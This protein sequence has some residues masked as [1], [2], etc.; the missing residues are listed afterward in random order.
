MGGPAGQAGLADLLSQLLQTVPQPVKNVVGAPFSE[1][2]G[3]V[4]GPGPERERALG[5]AQTVGGVVGGL[6]A[7][8][9]TKAQFLKIFKAPD[10]SVRNVAKAVKAKSGKVFTDPHEHGTA[11]EK[12]FSSGEEP[13]EFGLHLKGKGFI[14]ERLEPFVAEVADPK[15]DIF[16]ILFRMAKMQGLF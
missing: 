8:V 13:V 12:A 11:L 9:L 1:V 5:A 6:P 15:G 2:A 16:D 3:A 4:R 14:S 7:K 10:G